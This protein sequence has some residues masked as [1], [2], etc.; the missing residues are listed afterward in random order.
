M[1]GYLPAGYLFIFIFCKCVPTVFSK[2]KVQNNCQ[3]KSTSGRDYVGEANTTVDGIPCQRWSD[4]EPHDH[5]F[6]HVGDYNFCLN[7]NGASESH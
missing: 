6:T 7:P 2:S 3:Q 5:K 4:T 1:K